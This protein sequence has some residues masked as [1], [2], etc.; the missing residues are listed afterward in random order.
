MITKVQESPYLD[1][2]EIEVGQ[3]YTK[4]CY[5]M[6]VKAGTSVLGSG[7][8]TFYI[9]DHRANV[10]TARLFNLSNFKESGYNAMSF[11]G[12]PAKI[13][14]SAQ[15]YNNNL[16]IVISNIAMYS[17][18]FDY[19]RFL[20]NIASDE[21]LAMKIFEQ[22][23]VRYEIPLSFK[24]MSIQ[25]LYGGRTGGMMRL[26]VNT[27]RASLN[28][29]DLVDFPSFLK[30]IQESFL[31]YAQYLVEKSKVSIIDAKTTYSLLHNVYMR[32][33]DNLSAII[34]TCYALIA[35][36]SPKHYFSVIISRIVSTELS[37]SEIM[38]KI[39]SMPQGVAVTSGNVSII[40]Y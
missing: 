9:K 15:V 40:N 26:F 32:N 2:A 4:L 20:G 11:R 21:G 33:S 22:Y 1:L 29:A 19:S 6:N 13:T 17:G 36:G 16:S 31:F 34:D 38:I 5:V 23:G 37:N 14:F 10:T 18:T 35:D 27:V 7:Y 28:Y 39:N 30:T 24:T 25:E 12:K 8:Y 3:T